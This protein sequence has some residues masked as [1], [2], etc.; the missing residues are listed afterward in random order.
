LP[1]ENVFDITYRHALA[2]VGDD[3]I[4]GTTTGNLFS[5]NDGGESWHVLSNY[6]PMVYAVG[7]AEW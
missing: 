2:K 4:F 5:S 7:F 3:L 6:L 1:Q